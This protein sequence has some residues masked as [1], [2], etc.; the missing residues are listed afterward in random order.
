MNDDIDLMPYAGLTRAEF[1]K[2]TDGPTYEIPLS[3]VPLQPKPAACE[4]PTISSFVVTP[5]LQVWGE[6]RAV[7]V[8][9][10]CGHTYYWSSRGGDL[11]VVGSP[12]MQC[13]GPQ[14]ETAVSGRSDP[15]LP[16]MKKGRGWKRSAA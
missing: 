13:P 10:S 9:R 14:V 3:P 4:N 6:D 2:L 15:T 11:P 16:P 5:I 7:E 8:E 1:D 12:A